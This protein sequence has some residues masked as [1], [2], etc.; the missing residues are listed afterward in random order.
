ML[1]TRQTS[2][3]DEDRIVKN[4]NIR[5]SNVRIFD[6]VTDQQFL[7]KYCKMVRN[8]TFRQKF[9]RII[10]HQQ[11]SLCMSNYNYGN[12]L[13]MALVYKRN[14]SLYYANKNT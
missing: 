6:N 8:L 9:S 5:K 11:I 14:E 7:V 2:S 1:W 3:K 10:D 4:S 12:A 13:N